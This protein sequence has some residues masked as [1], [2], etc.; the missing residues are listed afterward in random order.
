MGAAQPA[1][2]AYFLNRHLILSISFSQPLLYSVENEPKKWESGTYL[3]EGIKPK[4]YILQFDSLFSISLKFVQFFCRWLNSHKKSA[5][6]VGS[7]AEN[8]AKALK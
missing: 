6:D 2:G 1:A 3:N 5:N 8:G 4:S 7:E